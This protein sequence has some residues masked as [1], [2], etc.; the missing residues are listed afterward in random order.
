LGS[1]FAL[2]NR[3][4]AVQ[5]EYR[6]APFGEAMKVKHYLTGA[7][8]VAA[9]AA[10]IH[11]LSLDGIHGAVMARVL[12]H[13]TKYAAGY[14]TRGFRAVRAGMT[15]SQ[16]RQ[17]LGPPMGKNWIYEAAGACDEV[18]IRGAEV[19]LIVDD[20]CRTKGVTARMPG[21]DVVKLL[22]PSRRVV[23][24]YTESPNSRNYRERLIFFAD[25]QVSH[26]RAALYLD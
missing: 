5:T 2:A 7:V 18:F 16:V 19:D 26:V 20:G 10:S 3:S 21:A 25:G 4:G 15:E 9:V 24:R 22:G 1:T 14:T 17:L 8:G 6:Y 11:Y 12:G 13:D 23:W